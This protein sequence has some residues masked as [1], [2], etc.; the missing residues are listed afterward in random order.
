MWESESRSRRSTFWTASLGTFYKLWFREHLTNHVLAM[1]EATSRSWVSGYDAIVLRERM[2]R[3]QVG[4]LFIAD[5]QTA[6]LAEAVNPVVVAF[7][8]LQHRQRAA[9]ETVE[10]RWRSDVVQDYQIALD[11]L[12]RQETHF[13]ATARAL[14]ETLN[15]SAVSSIAENAKGAPSAGAARIPPASRD[16]ADDVETQEMDARLVLEMNALGGFKR[17]AVQWHLAAKRMAGRV[18]DEASAGDRHSSSTSQPA[19]C[20]VGVA[21]S[22][23]REPRHLSPDLNGSPPPNAPP[24]A[25]ASPPLFVARNHAAFT[26]VDCVSAMVE[27]L[28]AE[29]AAST[30]SYADIDNAFKEVRL[31]KATKELER[32]SVTRLRQIGMAKRHAL[33][34]HGEGVGDAV[35]AVVDSE[36]H[37]RVRIA[38]AWRRGLDAQWVDFCVRRQSFRDAEVLALRARPVRKLLATLK[39]ADRAVSLTKAHRSGSAVLSSPTRGP[40]LRPL[41][42]GASR[43]SQP[44]L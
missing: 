22:A 44:V 11:I 39:Q 28:C 25:A 18:A 3:R 24:M 1:L 30:D 42:G 10:A 31:D 41:A 8:H 15:R 4:F 33:D 43:R 5:L 29:A 27:R 16:A 40:L 32:W 2:C 34:R 38:A 6:H 20:M 35:V 9:V 26:L 37:L 23:A 13:V 7:R 21:T 14:D 12:K 17:I 19:L 36:A